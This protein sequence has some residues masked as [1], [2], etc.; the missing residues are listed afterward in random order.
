MKSKRETIEIEHRLLD[1]QGNWKEYT[2]RR[3]VKKLG[4]ADH[5]VSFRNTIVPVSQRI[6]GCWHGVYYG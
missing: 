4:C 5:Y 2:I 3:V 1:A 6:N